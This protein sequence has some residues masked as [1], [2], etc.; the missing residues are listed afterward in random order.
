MAAKKSATKSPTKSVPT[1]ARSRKKSTSRK[2]ASAS[3]RQVRHDQDL[4][5]VT[6]ESRRTVGRVSRQY[7]RT[8]QDAFDAGVGLMDAVFDV[9][10][11]F[12]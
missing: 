9:I 12:W 11:L 2:R 6:T 1:K 7:R 4:L 10:N 8:T 5:K 3:K